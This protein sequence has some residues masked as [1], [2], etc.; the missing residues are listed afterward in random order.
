ML[1][2]EK[3]VEE[4]IELSNV[5]NTLKPSEYNDKVSIIP[6]LFQYH[7]EEHQL[8]FFLI[9]NSLHYKV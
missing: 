8:K 2:I 6:L 5:A 4:A 9:T 3:R 1:L 7:R